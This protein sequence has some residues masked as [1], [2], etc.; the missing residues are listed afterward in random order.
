MH[1]LSIDFRNVKSKKI[2]AAIL[3]MSMLFV[4]LFSL[5]YILAE[6]NH[7]CAGED[8][9]I[10]AC[11]QQCEHNIRQ[12]GTGIITQVVFAL[13][14]VFFVRTVEVWETNIPAATLVTQ[15]VRLNH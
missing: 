15:K 7:D 11:I 14:A 3:G 5:F 6:A 12:M 1:K 2:V 9:P 8:C 13:F 4:L 10:C